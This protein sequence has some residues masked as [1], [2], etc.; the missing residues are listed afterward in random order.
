[1]SKLPPSL[2][3]DL[4]SERF[5]M[6]QIQTFD[7]GTYSNVHTF[8][9]ANKGFMFVGPSGAGKSTAMDAHATLMTPPRHLAYNV[10]AAGD[11]GRKGSD[12]TALSYVRGA[13]GDKT[14][15][16]GSLDAAHQYLRSNSTWSAIAETYRN[17]AGH[18]ITLAQVLWI[19]GTSTATQDLRRFY[20]VF[21][22]EFDVKECKPF[23]ASDFNV[24]QFKAQID[25]AYA[26][27]EFHGYQECYRRLLGIENESALR[28]LHKTQS[29]KD[30][31]DLNQFLREFMLEPPE[32]YA[33]AKDLVDQFGELNEAHNAV[34]T[35]EQ[36]RDTLQPAQEAHFLR[37]S[38]ILER[39]TVDELLVGVDPYVEQ[40]KDRLLGVD[41]QQ[42]EVKLAGSAE[43]LRPLEE[44][45]Q[46][47]QNTLDRMRHQ[48]ADAGGR[49]IQQLEQ[50][51]VELEQQKAD[52]LKRRDR[53]EEAC[54]A[55]DWPL[56]ADGSWM[57]TRVA[58]SKAMMDAGASNRLRQRER[59][60]GLDHELR[61]ASERFGAVRLEIASME[62]STSNI[63]S[64]LL[65][66]R[67]RLAR[68]LRVAPEKL[69]FAGELME[70]RP[71]DGKWQGAM[72]RVLGGF[73][74]S[75][76][77]EDRYYE[78]ATRWI[79]EE[80]LGARV[81]YN[82]IPAGGQ[83]AGNQ[84]VGATSLVRKLQFAKTPLAEWVREELKARFDYE[85]MEDL[86]KFRAS[87][88][89]AVTLK[90]QVKHS[91]VR[92]EKNDR[93]DVNNRKHWVLGLDNTAKLAAYRE[94]AAALGMTI[95][96]LQTKLQEAQDDA[97]RDALSLQHCVIIANATWADI[98]VASVA[99]RIDK[100][101]KE[102]AAMRRESPDLA[103][104]ERRIKTQEAAVTQQNEK[105]RDKSAVIAVEQR[106]LS[107]LQDQRL[108]LKP[109][110]LGF[111]LSPVQLELLDRRFTETGKAE[112]V[113]TVSDAARAVDKAL[114]AQREALIEQ[115]H[116]KEKFIEAKFAEFVRRWEAAGAGRDPVIAS[117]EDFFATLAR[118]VEENLPAFKARFK[119]LLHDHS[120]Q[121]L[122][123]LSAR[124]ELE[125][126]QIA[127]R[128]EVVNEGLK[129]R[130]YNS[131]SGTHL[132]ILSKDR[133]TDDVRKFKADLKRALDHSLS[134]D[135]AHGE[136]RFHVVKEIVGRL[137]SPDPLDRK[138]R[139]QVL[140]V[141]QHVEFIAKELDDAGLEHE[142]YRSGSGKSGGQRQKLT[143]SILAAALRF[144][145]GGEFG[146]APRYNT[147]FM[148]EAFEKADA[149]FTTLTMKIFEAMGF[150]MIV[151]TPM[152]AVMALEPF[153]GG[154]AFVHSTSRKSS[155]HLQIDY[156]VEKGRLILSDKL[157]AEASAEAAAA[158]AAQ[159][160][161]T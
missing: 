86:Q 54:K 142:S 89:P 87:T 96:G 63:P 78:Q 74:T 100:A 81:F 98:D 18:I 109:E 112:A 29:T 124:L 113:A 83:T 90:G 121:A 154:A 57:A 156:D 85:C 148:D 102:I 65:D 80:H 24:R 62:T 7:W 122:I 25:A 92:H 68:A 40:L 35:A 88:R 129:S 64:F 19:K 9:I 31:G 95:A 145:L 30:L 33:V 10:A 93:F 21:K 42:R 12:R 41:I 79:E 134:D 55:L 158:N 3:S 120:S 125:R 2:P 46:A 61:K 49:K 59:Q 82:R 69:P 126:T 27:T 38:H 159:G 16:E 108:R 39:N 137:S 133:L 152:K 56:P 71:D 99:Q 101:E 17:K 103:E 67:D 147:V 131:E 116:G 60:S 91:F 118:L 144:Q 36:Q 52:R 105:V 4:D 50:S 97:E 32:T 51:V 140:D 150:Q 128:L 114:N 76:L 115:I 132:E 77:V 34:V 58:E 94:D 155:T 143:L 75:I 6:S 15:E 151:A 13:W 66:I 14:V 110:H 20:L 37:Q 5:W 8:K 139:D 107:R 141:R 146:E 138:W 72:E 22:R 84:N 44:L 48:L 73:A 123:R 136:A 157:R 117:A 23:A 153:I 28:L 47:E 135:E 45:A 70:V 160:G 104:L 111:R 119:K 43:E 53:V 127:D 106:E 161:S 1:M 26:D 130:I 11:G 149:E